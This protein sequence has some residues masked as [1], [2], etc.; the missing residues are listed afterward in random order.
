MTSHPILKYYDHLKKLADKDSVLFDLYGFTQTHT[1]ILFKKTDRD[2]SS[3]QDKHL[4]LRVLK[5]GKAGTSWTKDFSKKGLEECYQKAKETLNWIDRETAGDLSQNQNYESPKGFYPPEFHKISGEEKLKK[6]QQIHQ[7]CLG[8][9]P[10]VQPSYCYLVDQDRLTFFANSQQSCRAFKS[11]YVE[12]GSY[13]LASEDKRYANGLAWGQSREHSG[14]DGVKI[15]KQSADRALKKL[16][17]EIPQTKKYPVIFKAGSASGSLLTLLVD[18]MSAK[19]LFEGLSLLKNSLNKKLF[20]KDIFVYDDPLA[21]WGPNAEV[22]DAE[23]Y[24][25]EKTLLIEQGVLSNYLSSSFYAKKM[26]I[27]HTKKAVW[28]DNDLINSP[29]NLIMQEG[30]SS[31]E[32]LLSQSPELIV[33]DILKGLHSGY[34]PISGDFSFNSEGF[35]YKSGEAVPLCEFTVSGNILKVFAKIAKIAKDSQ[36]KDSVK[37]PSFLV[38]ELM[39]AGK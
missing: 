31:F 21:L 27:P 20:S 3:H 18:L 4:N 5:K 16:A 37:S 33:I 6:A 38:P 32:E 14:I 19:K 11:S 29:S 1:R 28:E 25:S 34:N 26:G 2:I 9:D 13:C 30:E 7:S 36:I 39:I 10:R 17:Y 8:F 35:L 12:G 15:G 24:S 22:F 23:G